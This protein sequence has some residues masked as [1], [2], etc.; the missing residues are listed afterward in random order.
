MPDRTHGDDRQL[1]LFGLPAQSTQPV[2]TGAGIDATG[3][4]WYPCGMGALGGH[5]HCHPLHDGPLGPGDGETF[6]ATTAPGWYGRYWRAAGESRMSPPPPYE[7][8]AQARAW[9][10]R[11]R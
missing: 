1:G 3:R 4:G 2:I 5:R 10:E 7:T 8:E 6:A 11:Q 9:V